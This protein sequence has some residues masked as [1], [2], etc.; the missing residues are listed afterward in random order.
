MYKP[1]VQFVLAYNYNN[2]LAPFEQVYNK[3]V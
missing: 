3:S 2:L 1:I